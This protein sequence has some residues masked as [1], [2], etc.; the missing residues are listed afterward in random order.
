MQAA[1]SYSRITRARVTIGSIVVE[2]EVTSELPAYVPNHV[3]YDGQDTVY[4][5]NAANSLVFRWSIANESYLDAIAVGM[6]GLAPSQMAYV[7]SQERLYLGYSSGAIQ[8]IDTSAPDGTE[9]PFGNTAMAVDGLAAVGNFLLAQDGSGAWATHYIF[10]TAGTITHQLDWNYYSRDYAWDPVTSRVYFF[11]DAFGPN[12]LHFEVINQANGQITAAGETP[13]HGCYSIEPPIRVSPNGQHVLLGS[14]DI[15]NQSDLTWAGS[16][17]TVAD[18]RW[19]ADGSIVTL[20]TSGNQTTLRRLSDSLVNLEQ[21]SYN[22]LGAAGRGL[23]YRHGGAGD[24]QRHGAVPHLRAQRRQRRRWR[25]Q[26]RGRLPARPGGLRGHRSRRLSRC[27]EP[28]HGP[29]R[30]HHR[31]GRSMPIRRTP[32]ATC[33]SMATACNCNYGATIPNYV[34]D[35]VVSDGDTIYLLSS[36]QPARV[37]L[38]DRHRQL[39]QSRTS[40]GIDQGFS[41]L[42]A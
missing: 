7:G 9:V 1:A 31:A 13:Y 27:L 20:T 25:A 28:G 8:Y 42:V 30:Q 33:R 39:S 15:Y 23:G 10:N 14:G 16:L 41:I 37:P 26:H 17:G 29:G 35:Q 38:V 19:L 11:R 32:R 12:D 21:L 3:A 6:D 4:L 36:G 22:G 24:R 2:F 34:P 40:I 18:A 5:L